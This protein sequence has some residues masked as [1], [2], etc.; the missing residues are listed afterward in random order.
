[1]GFI[2]IGDAEMARMDAVAE[3]MGRE[4]E[5]VPGIALAL[6]EWYLEQRREGYELLLGKAEDPDAP[7]ELSFFR[8][9]LQIVIMNEQG[10]DHRGDLDPPA[11]S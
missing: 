11:A 4:T 1:M 7:D 2:S 10:V 6:L 3:A 5:E 9:N 8:P